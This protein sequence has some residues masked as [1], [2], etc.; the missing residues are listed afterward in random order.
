M[1]EYVLVYSYLLIGIIFI[2]LNRKLHQNYIIILIFILGKTIVNY[3]K[4]TISYLEVYLR[5]VKKHEGYLY[6]L[7][8][9]ILNIRYSNQIGVIYLL[10][11]IIL[12]Y[13]FG[14]K[15]GYININNS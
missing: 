13:Y 15:D 12:Y 9:D 10:C 14:V 5:K 7:L 1:Y 6:T 8:D 3:R 11:S 2:I 4:C